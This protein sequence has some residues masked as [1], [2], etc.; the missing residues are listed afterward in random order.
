MLGTVICYS[1]IHGTQSGALSVCG[2]VPSGMVT[3]YNVDN[4]IPRTPRSFPARP[5]AGSVCGFRHVDE[6]RTRS[7]QDGRAGS[8]PRFPRPGKTPPFQPVTELVPFLSSPIFFLFLR[9]IYSYFNA[10]KIFPL[11]RKRHHA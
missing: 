10:R 1:V 8:P 5:S 9:I 4:V 3:S 2:F 11:T 7:A 6:D